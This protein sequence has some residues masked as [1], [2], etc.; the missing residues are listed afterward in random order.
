VTAPF[1]LPYVYYIVNIIYYICYF[2]FSL[3]HVV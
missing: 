2:D 1:T 3:T